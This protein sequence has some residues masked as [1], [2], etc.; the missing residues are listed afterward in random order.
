MCCPEKDF[1]QYYIEWCANWVTRYK[2]VSYKQLNPEVRTY[3]YTTDF[4][5]YTDTEPAWFS[6]TECVKAFFDYEKLVQ[7]EVGTGKKV[8]IESR[9]DTSDPL[10]VRT[11][12]YTYLATNTVFLWDPDTELTDCWGEKLDIQTKQFCDWWTTVF[13]TLVFDVSAWWANPPLL[14][15]VFHAIDGST[16]TPVAPVEWACEVAIPDRVVTIVQDCAW[17]TEDVNVQWTS[18][19]EVVI[20]PTQAIKV[21]VDKTCDVKQT[22]DVPNCAWTLDPKP[23]DEINATYLLNQYNK[24]T[25]KVYDIV[26]ATINW[27]VTYTYTAPHNINVNYSL[28]ATTNDVIKYIRTDYGDGYSDIWPNPD[29]SYNNDGAY[30]VKSYAVMESGNKIELFAQEVTILN[31]VVTYSSPTNPITYNRVYEVTVWCAL[32]DYCDGV[33]VWVPYNADTTAY[34]AIWTIWLCEAPILDELEDN[35]DFQAGI[36][37]AIPFE[38]FCL[39]KPDTT[40]INNWQLAPI[41]DPVN[42][43]A[44]QQS[45]FAQFP[46][47][48]ASF[49]AQLT[50]NTD[51]FN[52]V[53]QD[54]YG[55]N[56][57]NLTLTAA[58]L[59]TSFSFD[60]QFDQFSL[61]TTDLVQ[62]AIWGWVFDNAGNPIPWLWAV[63]PSGAIINWWVAYVA[64][65]AWA[66][67][68]TLYSFQ[69]VFNTP[70]PWNDVNAFIWFDDID[71][72]STQD[73]IVSIV[74]VSISYDQVIVTPW[75]RYEVQEIKFSDGTRE[76][77]KVLDNS[78]VTYDELVDI[79]TLWACQLP[80]TYIERL[81]MVD[82]ID[83]TNAIHFTRIVERTNWVVTATYDIDNTGTVYTPTWVVLSKEKDQEYKSTCYRAIAWWTGF[84]IGDVLEFNVVFDPRNPLTPHYLNR[85]NRSTLW[86]VFEQ[87]PAGVSG[88]FPVV[89][90]EVVP[91]EQYVECKKEIIAVE[92]KFYVTE[93]PSVPAW[94]TG[95]DF[96]LPT[97]YGTTDATDTYFH[98]LYLSTAYYYPPAVTNPTTPI[99]IDGNVIAINT[100]IQNSLVADGQVWDEFYIVVN[101]DKTITV[102]TKSTYIPTGN[103]FRLGNISPDNY[104]N[105]YF[106]VIPTTHST[107]TTSCIAIQE[108]KEKDSCTSLE[109]YRYVIEDGAG[110]LV[111]ASTFI[112]WW[113]EA[114]VTYSCP[115]TPAVAVV[116]IPWWVLLPTG[117]TFNTFPADVVSFT[118]SAQSG[119][120][121]ISFDSWTTFLSGR[122]WTRTRGQWTIETIDM[123]AVVVIS[124]GDIDIIRE[125]I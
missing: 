10:Q 36:K 8:L 48:P 90:T 13:G 32:Q 6:L 77:R 98:I 51:L 89:G 65:W 50:I 45:D 28:L 53:P 43:T 62:D 37:Q 96:D 3:Q 108:I 80:Q 9:T 25:E 49:P 72:G 82:F 91:C 11:T 56:Y 87:S 22:A 116:E 34:T 4:T 99:L 125:T 119:S 14:W 38:V 42:L 109:T 19:I 76:F 57:K 2:V 106:P 97:D 7:C 1:W 122:K 44:G 114:N 12:R 46:S 69:Y 110:T 83:P 29:H 85:T 61:D 95:Y 16:R 117:N 105:K 63:I 112:P 94:Y 84:N 86:N 26:I 121:D 54:A 66:V 59:V 41:S 27:P 60:V 123:T 92:P 70:H 71:T 47:Q 67:T 52:S 64:R 15:I 17:T 55:M 79:L 100:F 103:E 120:F 118:V 20:H 68:W 111:D 124:N 73:L 30:E 39:K 5:V 102:W 31:G 58:D 78:L 88:T 35:A 23:V 107:T 18:P 40:F 101:A 115:E 93:V 24:H 104:T 75:E 21:V 113:D 81:D 74:N 33:L